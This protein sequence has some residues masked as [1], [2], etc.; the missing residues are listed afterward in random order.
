MVAELKS[1]AAEL[2]STTVAC[3]AAAANA[4]SSPGGGSCGTSGRIP[5]RSLGN[6]AT[7]QSNSSG[8][9][10]SAGEG[11]DPHSVAVLHRCRSPKRSGSTWRR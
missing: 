5:A 2:Q 11:A 3:T 9:S 8:Q 1:A 6:L 4:P 10:D 7:R